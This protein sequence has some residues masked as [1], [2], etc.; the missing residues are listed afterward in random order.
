MRS[1]YFFEENVYRGRLINLI[2]SGSKLYNCS[3]PLPSLWILHLNNV[4]V[5]TYCGRISPAENICKQRGWL[6]SQDQIYPKCSSCLDL[7]ISVGRPRG[8]SDVLFVNAWK[9]RV[10]SSCH[11][12][13]TTICHYSLDSQCQVQ[14]KLPQIVLARSLDMQ[15]LSDNKCMYVTGHSA[16]ILI[17]IL[18]RS[19]MCVTWHV[20]VTCNDLKTIMPKKVPWKGAP[21]F[22]AELFVP[23]MLWNVKHF[24]FQGHLRGKSQTFRRDIESTN[25]KS[26]LRIPENMCVHVLKKC[27][28]HVQTILISSDTFIS[29][30]IS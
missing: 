3:H 24:S 27:S 29:V 13:W 14:S 28:V 12:L 19:C 1:Y 23:K 16:V 2:N 18:K 6:W 17:K 8:A 7:I 26:S 25:R 30:C 20:A 15:Q 9:G 11:I 5:D 10:S 21:G 4:E 22:S